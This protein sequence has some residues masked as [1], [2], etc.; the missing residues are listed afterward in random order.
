M[1]NY[2][3]ISIIFLVSCGGEISKPGH[4]WNPELEEYYW[5]FVDDANYYGATPLPKETVQVMD[6]AD[7]Y[8]KY[9]GVEQGKDTL[10]TC[11][12]GKAGKFILA[13][14]PIQQ[15]E[16][17]EILIKIT[18]LPEQKLKLLMYHEFGHCFLNLEH[19]DNKN[20]IMYPYLNDNPLLDWEHSLE[21]FFNGSK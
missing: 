10:G 14:K 9:P 16:W 2:Y 8:T 7:A 5:M 15:E 6:F 3:L 19:V 18:S 11:L 13:T 17:R 21:T 12:F 4:Y 1:L 20:H